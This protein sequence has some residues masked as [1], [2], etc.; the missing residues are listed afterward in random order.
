MGDTGK[1][2]VKIAAMP[3]KTWKCNRRRS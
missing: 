3:T 1:Y 2:S